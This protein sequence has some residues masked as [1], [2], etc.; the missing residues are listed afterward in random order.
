[1]IKQVLCATL[2]SIALTACDA[3]C[4]NQTIRTVISPD[5]ATKA[6]LFERD[7]GATTDFTSQLSIFKM[8]ATIS[9]EGGN[10]FVADTNHG[11]TKDTDWHGPSL[12]I[13]WLDS[14]HLEVL[15]DSHARVFKKE[16]SVGDVSIDYRASP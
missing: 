7:C 6:I 10:A 16:S 3:G 9:G 13:R 4:S 12:E 8:G 14:H 2:A 15:Y 1:M 5:K 11:K